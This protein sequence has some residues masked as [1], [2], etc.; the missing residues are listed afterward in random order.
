M[1]PWTLL[2][3]CDISRLK[4]TCMRAGPGLLSFFGALLRRTQ[5]LRCS[6]GLIATAC[7]NY[8]AHAHCAVQLMTTACT[9][10]VCSPPQSLVRFLV[11]GK[12]NI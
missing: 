7:L 2:D 6:R 3:P 4:N 5:P 10:P 8:S 9:A 11:L 1:L 12:G